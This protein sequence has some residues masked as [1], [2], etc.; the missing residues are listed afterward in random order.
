MSQNGT[1]VA[2]LSLGQ[3]VPP[4]QANQEDVG[5]WMADAFK[6]QPAHSRWLRSI[7]ANSG[8]KTRYACI[9]DFLQPPQLSRLTPG[10]LLAET[11]T[12]AERMA[13]YE[14]ESVILG[15]MAG[16][17]ALVAYAES[18]NTEL[19]A[20]S[21]VITHL[22]VV[23][24]TGFFAPGLDL[25]VAQKLNLAPTVER[26]LIGF[27]G[28]AAA[29][30]GLRVATQIIKNQPAAKVLIV[31]VEL[32]SIHIQPGAERENLI[33]GA[34]FADGASAGLVG[35]LEANHRDVFEIS[36]FHT[37]VKPG[38]RSEM[39]WKIGNYGFELRLS[40][41]IPEHLAEVAPAVLETLFSNGSRPRFWAIHPGGRAIVDRLAEI[42]QLAPE[43]V[44]A[45]R[46]VLSRV[47]NLSSATIFFVLDELRQN[48]RQRA[49]LDGK[50]EGVAM[51]FGPGLVI[52]MAR[53]VYLPP[54][55]VIAR[56]G[57]TASRVEAL[58]HVAVA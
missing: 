40:S 12:T 15:T 27:M 19:A 25:A 5:Q 45:T 48:L 8:I 53:L 29:F 28:C 7:Y 38:T 13:I 43:Q 57:A 58:S 37:R 9:P 35:A 52:E 49:T 46:S 31:C 39:V 42:F 54:V 17:R 47:G 16:Q 36:D 6:A 26:L 32:S 55:A 11:M 2:I 24:C 18:T 22:I 44:E 56:N 51:A 1:R 34:L 21:Q 3:A 23:S 14:R 33:A 20:V 10:R 4:Y 50:L 41:Q 30:N